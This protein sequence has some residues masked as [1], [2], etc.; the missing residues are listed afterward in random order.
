MRPTDLEH[1]V[2]GIIDAVQ[3]GSPVESSLVE[4]KS[5]WPEAK[6]SARRLAGHCNAA[7]GDPVLWIIGVDETE[8]VIGATAEETADWWAGVQSEFDHETPALLTNISIH[9]NNR[10]VIGLL[11]DSSRAPFVIKNAVHGQPNA[12]P[13]QLEV[14]WREGNSVRSARREDLIRLLVPAVRTPVLELL[15]GEAQCS[16]DNTDTWYLTAEFGIHALVRSPI[17]LLSHRTRVRVDPE[18]LQPR[19]G[20][21]YYLLFS[22]P[23]ERVMAAHRDVLLERSGAFDLRVCGSISGIGPGLPHE[24]T[25]YIDFGLADSNHRPRVTTSLIMTNRDDSRVFY[26]SQINFRFHDDADHT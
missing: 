18:H 12:G 3:R 6:R 19:P 9:T 8:G 22:H 17:V 11:F 20:R 4:L 26:E 21:S 24:I 10:T 23:D 14:P 15:S 1:R 5:A 16:R 7:R 13:V 2:L 25:M